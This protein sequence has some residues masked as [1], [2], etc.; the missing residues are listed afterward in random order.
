MYSQDLTLVLSLKKFP[1][2]A[3]TVLAKGYQRITSAAVVDVVVV[4]AEPLSHAQLFVTPWT[5]SPTG[6]SSPYGL[7]I[8]NSWSLLKLMSI[9]S[10]MPSNHL[11]LC[12]PLPLLPSIFP[13]IRV[14]LL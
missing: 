8:T 3:E 9:Q 4:V 7:S 5:A 14:M 1:Q 10:V 2:M 13:S 12:H 6:L 11:I